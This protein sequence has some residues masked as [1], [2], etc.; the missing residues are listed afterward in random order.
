MGG[1]TVW[2]DRAV[3]EEMSNGFDIEAFSVHGFFERYKIPIPEKSPVWHY[4]RKVS[5]AILESGIRL[6]SSS[7]K[8]PFL[9]LQNN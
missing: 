6:A 2:S 5:L 3:A 8:I 7:N 9:S 4:N 1:I